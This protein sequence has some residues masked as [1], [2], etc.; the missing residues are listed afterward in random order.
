MKIF[1]KMKRLLEN[2]DALSKARDPMTSQEE[3]HRLA[4]FGDSRV[5]SAIAE[6]PNIHPDTFRELAD[7][8]P[9]SASRNPS[10]FMWQLEDPN[11]LRS[12]PLEF[13]S[14]YVQNRVNSGEFEEDSDEHG[15]ALLDIEHDGV[16]N[17]PILDE[18][19]NLILNTS[20][21]FKRNIATSNGTEQHILAALSLDQDDMIRGFV[22][23]NSATPDDI[24]DTL[25]R[26]DEPLVR[27]SAAI[28]DYAP[29]DMLHRLSKDPHPSVRYNVASNVKTHPEILHRLKND[30]TME[31]RQAVAEHPMAHGSTLAHLTNDTD[32]NVRAKVA[33]N[34]NIPLSD[35]H[36][37]A[38]D[39][40]SDVRQRIAQN[41]ITK[42]D[43]LDKLG[44]DPH[45]DVRHD[46]A[47]NWGTHDSTLKRLQ[48]D[49]STKVA[50]AAKY[51]LNQ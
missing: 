48:N 2:E 13:K 46:V 23:S 6:N 35:L 18:N 29:K 36:K 32:A 40:S 4:L 7:S 31:V 24:L 3:L 37:L 11:F 45:E 38:D 51:S 5:R 20:R 14:S 30:N 1:N 25:S 12:M 17:H 27:A 8:Y 22:A 47:R 44:N 10:I 21:E 28:H 19:P 49:P 41:P 33:G 50:D 42:H 15:H 9:Q 43:L 39:P 34:T 26:D 16:V